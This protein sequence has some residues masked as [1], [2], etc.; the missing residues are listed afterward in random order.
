[1]TSIAVTIARVQRP[2]LSVGLKRRLA[3][4]WMP[5][6]LLLAAI[7]II[8][9]PLS[10]A[11]MWSLVDPDNPWSYPDAVPPSLSLFQWQHVFRYTDIVPAIITSYTLSPLSTLLSFLLALPTAYALGRHQFRG[12][13]TIRILILLPIILPGMAVAMFLSRVFGFL[14]LSQTLHGLVIGHT[15]MGLPFM[16]RILATSFEAIPQDVIDAA[17]NL[18]ASQFIK[19]KD[20]FIPMILPGMFAGSIFTFIASLEEFALTFVIGTPTYQTIPTILFGFM[21]YHFVRTN[22]AVVSLVLMVP[23]VILLFVV[24]RFLKSEYLGAAYGT[25]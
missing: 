22:A 19:I 5:A 15:L 4:L 2:W 23:N 21:G 25:V 3:R 9:L 20:I 16:I 6:L 7:V 17:E 8:G 18:G 1:M 24:E 10:M 11:V 12:K 13:E 14:G